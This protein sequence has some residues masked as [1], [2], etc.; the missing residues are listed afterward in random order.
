MPKVEKVKP[1]LSLKLDQLEN[2]GWKVSGKLTFNYR[3]ELR[4]AGGKW[5][6]GQKGWIFT[7]NPEAVVETL[8]KLI[9][10][11]E[12]AKH[13][14][15]Q[16]RGRQLHQ[17]KLRHEEA[18]KK[19]LSEKE[20]FQSQWNDPVVRVEIDR[21]NK[22]IFE[23]RGGHGGMWPLT[24]ESPFCSCG[25]H[26]TWY[27]YNKYEKNVEKAAQNYWMSCPRCGTDYTR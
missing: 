11:E 9:V 2:S 14:E 13:K 7:M 18:V 1:D 19:L 15:R 12:E 23:F 26:V 5:E 27:L 10:E 24:E 25:C 21:V 6:A 4:K 20:E 8:N 17:A 22:A 16:E 3:T